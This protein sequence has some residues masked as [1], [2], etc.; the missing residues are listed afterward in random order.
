[1][2]GHVKNIDGVCKLLA[3]VVHVTLDTL[4]AKDRSVVDNCT[5]CDRIRQRECCWR[6]K[7]PTNPLDSRSVFVCKAN[8]AVA[9]VEH[10][11][12]TAVLQTAKHRRVHARKI[13]GLR[14]VRVAG[15]IAIAISPEV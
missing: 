14:H 1:M 5:F 11:T 9:T 8:C 6:I 13:T 7:L 2:L 15:C 12:F 3:Q 4:L 10:Q